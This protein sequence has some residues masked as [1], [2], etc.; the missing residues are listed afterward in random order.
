MSEL[1]HQLGLD[2][3]LL[4][5]QG[6]NFLILLA[7]LTFLVY[8]P[9]IKITEERR[10]KIELGLAGA[11]EAEKRLKQIDVLKEEKLAEAD[12]GAIKII[13]EAEKKG[14]KRFEEI[15]KNAESRADE[16]MV[17][18]TRVAEQ[19]K[20]EELNRLTEKAN[21]LIKEAIVKMV[22]LDPK[23]IDDKLISR[24][25]EVIRKKA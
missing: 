1:I 11:E 22:E 13:G 3:K 2:W 10:K 17:E 25:A 18:A 24:A 6:V 23:Y 20:Q 7:S 21:A 8:K 14:S 12:K 5:S 16:V 4:A 9:L 19:K 15:L